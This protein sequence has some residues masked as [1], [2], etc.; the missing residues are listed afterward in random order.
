[1][2]ANVTIYCLEQITDYF[3]FERLCH[4]LM[5]KI[6][7][8]SIE[9]L[10]GFK[11]KGRDAIHISQAGV[12]TVFA[13]SVREDWRAKL[14]ED[15]GKIY[16][17]S[18]KCD[19][20]VFLSTAHYTAGERDE[21][22]SFVKE[23][24]GWQL[25]L[26]GLER[27]R[28]LLE[29]R[30]P[31]LRSLHPQIF[32]PQFY[33]APIPS[34]RATDKEHL[35]ISADPGD[36]VLAVWLANKLTSEG[37]RVWYEGAHALI[38]EN[39]P[40]NAD[41][42]IREGANKVIA[43]YSQQSLANLEALRQRHLALSIG[44]ERQADFLIP[45]NIDGV[46]PSQL[47]RLTATLTF[48]SFETNWAQGLRQLLQKLE[49]SGCP[50]PLLTGRA[51]AAAAFLENDVLSEETE[52]VFSNCLPIQVLPEV[53]HCFETDRDLYRS[54]Q[55]Q[56]RLEWAFRSVTPRMF[57]SFQYPDGPISRRFRFTP[58]M[59]VEWAS[60]RRLHGIF[61]KDLVIE[62]LR[63]SLVVKCNQKGLEF[64]VDTGMQY[65]PTGL[66]PNDRLQFTRPDG[67]RTF[68]QV[69]GQRK[70]WRPQGEQYY[71]YYLSPAFSVLRHPFE[72]YVAL[73]RMRVRITD[74]DGRLLTKRS[75]NARR[76]HLCK[77]WWNMHWF[78]R[79]LAICQFLADDGRIVIGNSNA[80]LISIDSSPKAMVAPFSI[81]ENR[82][83][84]GAF[85]RDEEMLRLF[86]D[87][88]DEGGLS[89]E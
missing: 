39:Y 72:E 62:L 50:K 69:T 63:K 55:Q 41:Q 42:A 33:S 48:I 87:E 43:L 6:G 57:L 68:V 64:C 13:Y 10:G 49:A 3:E 52:L 84:Y 70:Y 19:K 31:D 22:V 25:D 88:D 12:S 9:P 2:G 11:D 78:N 53:I 5:A 36:S 76:K 37:Y 30:Y 47:D 17:H 40:E 4:D 14:A 71:R 1:M 80:E 58:I 29:T 21:A 26:F 23:Q 16:K 54:T 89:D 75:G 15:A 34:R 59:H 27:L 38:G 51:I 28:V 77:D 18:H 60:E 73:L 83:D 35:Y 79:T 7:Y 66:V 56:L 44:Q 61:V 8:E 45:L 74:M 82:L 86:Q 67:T 46:E 24:Y 65:F 85:E 20:L 81:A 32:P